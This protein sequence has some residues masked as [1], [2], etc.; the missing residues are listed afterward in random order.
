MKAKFAIPKTTKLE[1]PETE[2]KIRR[3]NLDDEPDNY[4]SAKRSNL[5]TPLNHKSSA[6][7]ARPIN[8]AKS[9]NSTKTRPSKKT[10]LFGIG[11]GLFVFIL[12]IVII[13][14]G[15]FFL[16]KRNLRQNAQSKSNPF[17]AQATS[18]DNKMSVTEMSDILK[19]AGKLTI[20]PPEAPIMAKIVDAKF[21]IAQSPFYKDAQSGD[22]IIIY[23]T[24]QKAFIYS[25]ARNIIVNSGPII[26]DSP[27]P[28]P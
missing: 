20:L 21:L 5:A 8:S 12:I 27:S 25:P 10:L 9:I 4:Q 19:R 17:A 26:A 18:K 1:K 16:T 24:S 3:L 7:S 2:I 22:V 28:S 23:P 13:S 14:A 6:E 15:V 11:A